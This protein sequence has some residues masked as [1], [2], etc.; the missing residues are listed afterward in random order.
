MPLSLAQQDAQRTRTL[1]E[2]RVMSL[3]AAEQASLGKITLKALTQED[4]KYTD[5]LIRNKSQWQEATHNAGDRV[6]QALL[7]IR[8][9]NPDWER[10]Y[11]ANYKQQFLKET[12][13]VAT[14]IG[15]DM[16]WARLAQQNMGSLEYVYDLA[17]KI[18]LDSSVKRRTKS[19]WEEAGRP[20]PETRLNDF[21]FRAEPSQ[22]RWR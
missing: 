3:W 7:E 4:A 10:H 21:R 12:D 15:E 9:K 2:E 8:T 17:R 1:H 5:I 6:A 14:N 22:A 11:I 16:A 19:L 13:A 18:T 20:Q